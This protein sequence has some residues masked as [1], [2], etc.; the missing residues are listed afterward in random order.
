MSEYID[1]KKPKPK[2]TIIGQSISP[3]ETPSVREKADLAP[4]ETVLAII[5]IHT[6]PGVR[7]R[8]TNAA[9]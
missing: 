3:R 1:I 2:K 7:K 8:I 5:A 4:P 6:G 9:K